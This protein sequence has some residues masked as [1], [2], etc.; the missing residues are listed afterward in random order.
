M[1]VEDLG[2][3]VV[4]EWLAIERDYCATCGA[5]H[6]LRGGG[7]PLRGGPQTRVHVGCTLRH[8]AELQRAA[9]RHELVGSQAREKAV[10]GIAPMRLAAHHAHRRGRMRAYVNG[11]ACAFAALA[12]GSAAGQPR[13]E[14]HTSELQ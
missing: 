2:L 5:D 13:S 9:D 4:D 3:R 10:E 7:V 12:P 11:L 14:E 8:H 6:G 1:R